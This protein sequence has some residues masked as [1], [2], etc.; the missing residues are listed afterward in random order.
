MSKRGALLAI[1]NFSELKNFVNNANIRQS[2]KFVLIWYV[3]LYHFPTCTQVLFDNRRYMAEILPIRQ[4]WMRTLFST[5]TG[6]Q[7]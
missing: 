1:H 5:S 3:Q 4:W 7:L 2:L 6:Y